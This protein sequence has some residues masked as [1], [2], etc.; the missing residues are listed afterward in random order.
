MESREGIGETLLSLIREMAKLW[1]GSTD[2]HTS[3]KSQQD[4]GLRLSPDL[5]LLT[6]PRYGVERQ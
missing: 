4:S 3:D 1:S 5:L 6:S 2:I